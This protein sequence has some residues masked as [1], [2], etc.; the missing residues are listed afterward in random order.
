MDPQN[1]GVG[2]GD[3]GLKYGHVWYLC[4]ISEV[5]VNTKIEERAVIFEG[6][7]SFWGAGNQAFFEYSPNNFGED[8][9]FKSLF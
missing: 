4:S 1:D 8:V 3:S 2:K 5:R 9:H 6:D 7:F